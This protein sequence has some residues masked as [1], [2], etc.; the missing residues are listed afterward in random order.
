MR[1]VFELG[2]EGGALK[3]KTAFLSA[4]AV[5]FGS[6]FGEW[7]CGGHPRFDVAVPDLLGNSWNIQKSRWQSDDRLPKEIPYSR[8][9]CH[10]GE[11][12]W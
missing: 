5:R 9:A 7:S 3:K 12:Q 6:S 4:E 8:R 11:K 2:G 10:A 1:V